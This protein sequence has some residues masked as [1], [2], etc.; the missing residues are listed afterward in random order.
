MSDGS[1]GSRWPPRVIVSG[2][3]REVPQKKSMLLFVRL[4]SFC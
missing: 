1:T 4:Q 2:S 3:E